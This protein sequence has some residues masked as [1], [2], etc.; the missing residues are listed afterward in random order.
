M[1]PQDDVIDYPKVVADNED[2]CNQDDENDHPLSCVM[3]RLSCD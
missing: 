2:A 3:W 1:G